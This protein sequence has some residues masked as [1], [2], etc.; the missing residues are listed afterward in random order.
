MEQITVC[1]IDDDLV[2]RLEERAAK[3]GRSAEDEVRAILEK[4]LRLDVRAEVSRLEAEDFWAL[5]DRLRAE[6]PPQQ[7]DSADLVRRIMDER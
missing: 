5:A 3:H 4:A 1:D 6:T 7:S 2:R